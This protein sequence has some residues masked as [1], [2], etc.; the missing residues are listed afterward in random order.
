MAED[1]Y[2]IPG[3][4]VEH[5]L[6]FA[7]GQD[8]MLLLIHLVL[9]AVVLHPDLFPVRRDLGGRDR[10]G[11]RDHFDILLG[12][13]VF[14]NFDHGR[15]NGRGRGNTDGPLRV[16]R[17]ALLHRV[18]SP[19]LGA[20]DVAARVLLGVRVV[21]NRHGR[22]ASIVICSRLRPLVDT[23]HAL[24]HR[25]LD[26][27]TG[28]FI[29]YGHEACKLVRACPRVRK[30]QT[31]LFDGAS[32]ESQAVHGGASAALHLAHG[33]VAIVDGMHTAHRVLLVPPRQVEAHQNHQGRDAHGTENAVGER[34]AFA[35]RVRG[36]FSK[37]V[38]A[39]HR[40]RPVRAYRGGGERSS[41]L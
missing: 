11:Q 24:E 20:V 28:T 27:E 40:T 38:A 17:A 31:L 7:K 26:S 8:A 41:G 13:A 9:R 16:T 37:L 12:E 10:S 1:R 29:F 14:A 39:Q 22:L 33:G 34:A 2:R 4:A 5:D 3:V 25:N 23:L 36:D 32:E 21:F 15:V 19:E 6:H 35:G 30:L 18:R